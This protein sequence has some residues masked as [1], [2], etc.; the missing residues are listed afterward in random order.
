[1]F[2]KPRT[3]SRALFSRIYKK[4]LG[5]NYALSIVFV[6]QEEIQ[7]LHY[8]YRK[9]NEPTDILSFARDTF[10]GE[11]FLSMPQVKSHAALWGMTA[12]A[13]LPYV[14]IHGMIHLKGV[15]HG[16]TMNR[17]EIQYCRALRLPHP[18]SP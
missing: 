2:K 8:R 18:K 11:L 10:S 13:Y 17:L 16:R 3:V 6:P 9:K 1:M 7:K 4:V 5:K 12:R 14:V 15:A